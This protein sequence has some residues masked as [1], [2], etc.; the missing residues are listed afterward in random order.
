VLGVG[1]GFELVVGTVALVLG[2]RLARLVLGLECRVLR[3][4]LVTVVLVNITDTVW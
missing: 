4:G 3:L 2:L 1:L